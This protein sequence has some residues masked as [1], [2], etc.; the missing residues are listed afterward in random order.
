MADICLGVNNKNQTVEEMLKEI[1]RKVQAFEGMVRHQIL[2]MRT[3]DLNEGEEGMEEEVYY[4]CC[5]VFRRMI[6][7][8]TN[9]RDPLTAIELAIAYL[10]ENPSARAVY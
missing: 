9:V 6:P 3:P 7:V 8:D 2:V 10:D 4:F 1:S 5:D